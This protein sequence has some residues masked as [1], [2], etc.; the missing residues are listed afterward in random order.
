MNAN[1]SSKSPHPFL[2]SDDYK[3]AVKKVLDKAEQKPKPEQ[4]QNKF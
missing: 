4:S 3:T 2:K 1:D